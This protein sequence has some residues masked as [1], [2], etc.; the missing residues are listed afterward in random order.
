MRTVRGL[1]SILAFSF[2]LIGIHIGWNIM[3]DLN[4]TMGF[5]VTEVAL[6]SLL[7]LIT[8]GVQRRDIL[9][10]SII[11]FIMPTFPVLVNGGLIGFIASLLITAGTVFVFVWVREV[12]HDNKKVGA[13][14]K[15][16]FLPVAGFFLLRGSPHSVIQS[17][18]VGIF[19]TGII[20]IIA[21]ILR[22]T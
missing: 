10:L 22:K 17:L 13:V 9:P 12:A 21:I 7:V 6:F 19:T 3:K 1:H 15:V 8:E 5:I 18:V 20:L 2:I 4:W 11:A 16:I 14:F